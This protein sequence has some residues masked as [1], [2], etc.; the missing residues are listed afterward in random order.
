MITSKYPSGEGISE[1]VSQSLGTAGA[2]MHYTPIPLVLGGTVTAP[3]QR[4]NLMA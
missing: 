3:C 1:L 4:E 2:I